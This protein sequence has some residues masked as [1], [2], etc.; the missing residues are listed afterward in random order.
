MKRQ[1]EG[2]IK[3][4]GRLL[5]AQGKM[6]DGRD[7]TIV[8]GEVVGRKEPTHTV[9]LW[10]R[11]GEKMVPFVTPRKRLIDTDPI[12]RNVWIDEVLR[13]AG[14]RTY[15]NEFSYLT[16]P[17]T[18]YEGP[19]IISPRYGFRATYYALV[20]LENGSV[21]VIYP[22]NYV[23]NTEKFEK[24]RKFRYLRLDKFIS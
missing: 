19:F 2:P 5:V 8:I 14:F 21:D 3:Y 16:F 6:R 23:R 13:E 17:V 22:P 10:T 12:E 1:S 7:Q 15:K 18:R 20:T 4:I 11:R 24:R 9:D